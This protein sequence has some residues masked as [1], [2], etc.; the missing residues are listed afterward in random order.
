VVLPNQPADTAFN[1]AE[2]FR[3][4][5][6]EKACE[7]DG[8]RLQATLS[9]GVAMF[10]RDGRDW[11]SLFAAADRHCYAAKQAGRNRVMGPDGSPA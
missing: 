2:R 4:S 11:D 3:I 5:L 10:P 7:I 1:T 8:L 9:G 6:A